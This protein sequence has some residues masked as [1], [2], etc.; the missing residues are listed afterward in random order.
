VLLDI[1]MPD[2]DGVALLERVKRDERWRDVP[3]LVLSSAPAEEY[4][5]RALG[6]GAAD[7]VR[8]PVRPREL[9]ARVQAH[10]RAGAALRTTRE[11]LRRTEAELRARAPTPRTASSSSTSCTRS[12]ATSPPTRST[13]CSRGAWRAR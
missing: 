10:L 6:L 8:K 3:V 11:A 9:V 12:P 5:V 7:F 4:T 2:G 1:L 13:T